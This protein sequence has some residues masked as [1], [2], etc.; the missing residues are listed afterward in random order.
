[1]SDDIGAGV[2]APMTD[3]PV[4]SL[5]VPLAIQRRVEQCFSR[6]QVVFPGGTTML[7]AEWDP[8]FH[9]LAIGVDSQ[10]L[11]DVDVDRIALATRLGL[12]GWTAL[13]ASIR[14]GTLGGRRSTRSPGRNECGVVGWFRRRHRRGGNVLLRLLFNSI[15]L[16][17]FCNVG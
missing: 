8:R 4:L 5:G 11:I 17:E 3:G 1:M 15:A 10:V 12:L 6:G 2:C 9:Q 7:I 13:R 16:P 14:C